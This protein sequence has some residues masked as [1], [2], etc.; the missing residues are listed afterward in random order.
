MIAGGVSFQPGAPDDRNKINPNAP[1]GTQEGV[2]EAIKVLSLRLPKVVGAQASVPSPL[3]N[4]PGNGGRA[5]SMVAQVMQK[6]FPTNAPAPNQAP[7]M[8]QQQ[9][10]FRGLRQQDIGEDRPSPWATAPRIIA[11]GP[12]V[13]APFT[14]GPYH[15][16]SPQ[17]EPSLGG[18]NTGFPGM[19]GTPAPD[20]KQQLDWLPSKEETPLI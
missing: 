8:P 1:N 16:G 18:F 10:A 17:P 15:P 5:D 3:L 2:Q 9:A 20:L 14:G 13:E 7:G 6:F 19:I 12:P 4:A 11:G